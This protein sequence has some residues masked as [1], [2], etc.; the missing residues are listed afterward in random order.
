MILIL[1][2]SEDYL[3]KKGF[4]R[5][6]YHALHHEIQTGV[7][8]AEYVVLIRNETYEVIKDR[9]HG[10]A[11]KELPL[12]EFPNVIKSFIIEHLK[13]RDRVSTDE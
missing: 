6:G 4:Q 12:G 13:V 2:D 11:M 5:N 1:D 10:A 3:W 8:C 9:L 7:Q